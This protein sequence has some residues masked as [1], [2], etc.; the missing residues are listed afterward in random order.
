MQQVPYW[1]HTNTRRRSTKCSRNVD[2]APGVCA[3]LL[4]RKRRLVMVCVREP[5]WEIVSQ[6]FALMKNT[7]S[8]PALWGGVLCVYCPPELPRR[9][10]DPPHLLFLPTAARL[11]SFSPCA[12]GVP[13][14]STTVQ[15]ERLQ[16]DRPWCSNHGSPGSVQW[17]LTHV[18]PH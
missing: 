5:V 16:K 4:Q 9:S 11:H 18:G 8:R 2:L 3:P 7:V 17:R 1:G 15:K 6:H 10:Q 12:M 13:I 14:D